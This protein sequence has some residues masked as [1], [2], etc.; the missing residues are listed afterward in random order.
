MDVSI[1]ITNSNNDTLTP[2]HLYLSSE[3][4]KLSATANGVIMNLEWGTF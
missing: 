1:G 4:I 2:S 3:T